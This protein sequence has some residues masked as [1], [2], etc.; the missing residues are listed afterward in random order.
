MTTVA[1]SLIK[2]PMG[3]LSISISGTTS[4]NGNI[5]LPINYDVTVPVSANIK[6][7]S[8]NTN[9][10]VI[11]GRYS[12]PDDG[13]WGMKVFDELLNN[14]QLKPVTSQ[15]ISGTLYYIKI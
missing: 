11:F 15:T 6:F 10:Y 8:T 1:E 14:G 13:L 9:A 7:G 3:L 5:Q 12:N 2:R 4:A